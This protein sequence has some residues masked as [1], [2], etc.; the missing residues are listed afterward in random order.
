[1]LLALHG[2]MGMPS[3]QGTRALG[4]EQ[5]EC[6]SPP[7]ALAESVNGPHIG[8][9]Q[10]VVIALCFSAQM[11]D[12][13]D[14]QASAFVAPALAGSWHV[15]RAAFGAVFGAGAFGTLIGSLLIGPIGDLLGRKTLIV[16]SLGLS[17]VL[18]GATPLVHSVSALAVIRFL[19][20][21]PLGALI[22]GT[23]VVANEWVPTRSRTTLVTMMACGFAFG[24]VLGGQLS[25]ILLPR[26]G[27][28]SVFY[29][30]ALGSAVVCAAI[31]LWLPESLRF[32]L[33]RPT[34]AKL[35]RAQRIL[36]ALGPE[37]PV[38]AAPEPAL[39]TSPVRGLF[40]GSRTPMTLL[41]WSAFFANALVLNFMTFWLPTL[42]MT[43]GL[44]AAT[45]IRLSTLF[46][47]G[48][49]VGVVFMGSV[50]VRLNAWRVVV[51]GYL[52]S[53][54]AVILVGLLEAPV[55]NAAILF[56]GFGII[57]V[58]MSLASIGACLYPTEM[59][60]TGTSWALGMGRIGSTIGPLLGGILVGQHWAQ[61]RLFETMALV[62]LAGSILVAVLAKRAAAVQLK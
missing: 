16:L 49:I 60:A 1:M 57:G 3:N 30:G 32:L 52:L 25:A 10:L 5:Q 48:G 38:T 7:S 20:G 37:M 42:L 31:T 27:W 15:S 21:L 53:A 26:L 11:I 14:N 56:S 59:R 29:A 19:T 23:I 47:L 55:R 62:P 4:T 9:I 35:A 24:A 39:L 46:Q 17:A 2:K 8:A 33:L 18:M 36:G 61:P 40:A 51:A 58:Q 13:F 28:H 45:A 41:L 12:G 43:S 6:P 44:E 50:S 54:A 22:P 34:K